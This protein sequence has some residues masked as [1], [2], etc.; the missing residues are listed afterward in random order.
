MFAA[1]IG[2]VGVFTEQRANA[3]PYFYQGEFLIKGYEILW[4]TKGTLKVES[5]STPENTNLFPSASC[6]SDVFKYTILA[7]LETYF[8]GINSER[9]SF[10]LGCCQE[11]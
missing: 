2:A 11:G 7:V 8:P 10:G 5:S 4:L 1:V 6:L 9:V 3:D